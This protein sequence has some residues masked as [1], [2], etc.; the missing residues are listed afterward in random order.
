MIRRKNYD[1]LPIQGNV[2]PMS[3]MAY[4]EDESMRLTVL[5][6]Q[7]SGVASLKLGIFFVL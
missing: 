2:Y 5:S 6:G 7:S 1:K 3:T 4:L